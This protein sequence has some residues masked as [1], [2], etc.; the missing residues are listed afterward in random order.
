[1][2]GKVP[3]YNKR[4]YTARQKEFMVMDKLLLQSFSLPFA[5][6]GSGD[7]VRVL[8]LYTMNTLDIL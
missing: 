1:M 4:F 2:N 8:C 5:C 7:P 3:D 6:I